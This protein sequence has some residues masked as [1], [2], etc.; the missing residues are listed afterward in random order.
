MLTPSN[1]H[2]LASYLVHDRCASLHFVSPLSS[3]TNIF[4]WEPFLLQWMGALSRWNLLVHGVNLSFSLQ[5]TPCLL[6]EDSH[7]YILFCFQSPTKSY[8]LL[9]SIQIIR[10]Y[11]RFDDNMLCIYKILIF[12]DGTSKMLLRFLVLM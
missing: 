6:Q 5:T 1:V 3:N 2:T 8:A 4:I 12:S 9:D 7:L 11:S 10:S